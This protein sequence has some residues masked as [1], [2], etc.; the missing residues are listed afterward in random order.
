MLCGNI[1]LQGNKLPGIS[2]VD[3]NDFCK[4][5]QKT[6]KRYLAVHFI[7]HHFPMGN[8]DRVS[9]FVLFHLPLPQFALGVIYGKLLKSIKY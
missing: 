3:R 8:P 5:W 4:I 1:I 7:I 2:C 9:G 6:Y